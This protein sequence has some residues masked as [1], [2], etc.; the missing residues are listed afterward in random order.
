MTQRRTIGVMEWAEL[1]KSGRGFPIRIVLHGDSMRPLIRRELD[2]VTIVPITRD[3]L[4]GDV[5]LFT[6]G[7]RYVVHRII[8]ISEDRKTIITL[9]DNC[10]GPDAPLR[11]DQ[12][13]GLVTQYKR[14][15]KTHI[16]DSEEARQWGLRHAKTL[17]ARNAY[18]KLRHTAGKIIK[19]ILGRS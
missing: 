15:G 5:V 16:L 17:R 19:P 18:R 10:M 14:D 2:P 9:G 6:D 1:A 11:P 3:L 4:L 12:I 7:K 8:S 13:L